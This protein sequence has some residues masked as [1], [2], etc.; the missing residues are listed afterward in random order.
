M[1]TLAEMSRLG[2]N[3]PLNLSSA[4]LLQYQL[5]HHIATVSSQNTFSVPLD[6][7]ENQNLLLQVDIDACFTLFLYPIFYYLLFCNSLVPPTL[8]PGLYVVLHPLV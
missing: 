5:Q 8:H 1:P 7:L 3:I 6:W 4:G 2:F